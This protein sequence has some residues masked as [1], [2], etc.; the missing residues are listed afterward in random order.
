VTNV[1]PNSRVA[2]AWTD[3]SERHMQDKSSHV[4]SVLLSSATGRPWRTTRRPPTMK[5]KENLAVLCAEFSLQSKP[6]YPNTW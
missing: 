4:L 1:I 5:A 3:M 6:T 2:Q